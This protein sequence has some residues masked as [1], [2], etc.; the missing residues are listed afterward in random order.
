MEIHKARLAKN[1]FCYLH[2]KMVIKYS[3]FTYISPVLQKS[4]FL[5]GTHQL[6]QKELN[7]QL[8]SLIPTGLVRLSEVYLF[9]QLTEKISIKV[10][11]KSVG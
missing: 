4:H 9:D 1:L 3:L 7:L 8:L 6:L 11:A 2:P 5:R 10:V